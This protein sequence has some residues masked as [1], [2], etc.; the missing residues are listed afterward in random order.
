MLPYP[1]YIA[2]RCMKGPTMVELRE[3]KPDQAIGRRLGLWV[4]GAGVVGAV[5]LPA[6]RVGIGWPI[7]ALALVGVIAVARFDH[8]GGEAG[9]DRGDRGWRTAAG[10]AALA[11]VAVAGV[12]AAG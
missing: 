1:V 4:A 10:V 2:A 7:A 6:W 12:R 9:S 8:D 3:D 11:L 5:A